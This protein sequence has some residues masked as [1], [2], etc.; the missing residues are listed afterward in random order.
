MKEFSRRQIQR[1]L[2]KY[3]L[4]QWDVVVAE[5]HALQI[6]GVTD[7]YQLLDRML[8][9]DEQATVRFPYWAEVWPSSLAL[10]RWFL[11]GAEGECESRTAVGF[12]PGKGEL[13]ELGCGLG[14]LGICAARAGW[15]VQATDFVEDALVFA[16]H[17]A[18]SNA[19]SGRFQVGYLDWRRPVGKPVSCILGADLVYEK[20]HHRLLDNLLRRLLLPGGRFILADPRRPAARNF[21]QILTQQDYSHAVETRTVRW[22]STV[23]NVHIH[24]FEKPN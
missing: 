18:A 6:V 22:K 21:C 4:E 17:N 5:G 9:K 20:S 24:L 1:T 15:Q 16:A 3:D 12:A 10:G 7:P 23:H 8:E 2:R 13:L 19:V 14:L 11:E